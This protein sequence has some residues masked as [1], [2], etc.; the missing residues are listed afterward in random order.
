[1][2]FRNVRSLVA[3]L[4]TLLDHQ[5]NNLDVRED[6]LDAINRTYLDVSAQFDWLFLQ[7]E[8]DWKVW[9]EKTGTSTGYTVAVTNGSLQITFSTSLG[10]TFTAAMGGATFEDDNGTTYTV[11]RW[12]STTVAYLDRVY[13][14]TTRAALATWTVGR[15]A[16]PLPP[17]CLRPLR[18]IDRVNGLGV[19]PI[20]DRRREENY[21]ATQ[22]TQTGTPYWLVDDDASYD[23]APDPGL[24]G[25]ASTAA[26]T[27]SANS[28][29]E[30]CY[31]FTGYG[32]E[33][34]PGPPVRVTTGSSGAT[35]QVVLTAIENTQTS[36]ADSG[37]KKKVYRRDIS[38]SGALTNTF[39]FGRWLYLTQLDE[40][41][42]SFTDDGAPAV[43]VTE[44]VALRFQHGRKYMRPK[45]I[46]SADA[47]LRLR[48][49]RAPKRLVADSDVPMWPEAYHDLILYGAAVDL[50]MQH[51]LTGK[52]PQWEKQRDEYLRRMK[53]SHLAVP[54]AP[55]RKQRWGNGGGPNPY[56]AGTPTGD[57]TG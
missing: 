49:L 10:S 45:W 27:L 8:A 3:N 15:E 14:G 22:S 29:Y 32:R 56:R 11:A 19:L 25:T 9:A 57:F 37:I 40:S 48:Y 55:T 35:H 12:G 52:V 43:T 20:L 54:D 4:G 26:G 31:T 53:A 41:D 33:S 51:G 6:R 13:E 47:T 46:P 44:D 30:Y 39:T 42:V 5:P 38:I 21:F 23:R 1:M 24:I 34:P 16:Y 7:T 36:G 17:D 18:F 2:A 50:G 28:I